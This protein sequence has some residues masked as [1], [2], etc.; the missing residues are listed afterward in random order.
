MIVYECHEPCKLNDLN[1]CTN[2]PGRCRWGEFAWFV[3]ANLRRYGDWKL[4]EFAT[5]A[6]CAT[7][8]GKR[9]R[10]ELWGGDH[11]REVWFIE[12]GTRAEASLL[13]PFAKDKDAV[14]DAVERGV[15]MA[16]IQPRLEIEA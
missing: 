16:G 12:K 5:G 15:R 9:G 6:I 11:A 1:R 13:R 7:L 2:G 3:K 4:R 14:I 10:V 8:H